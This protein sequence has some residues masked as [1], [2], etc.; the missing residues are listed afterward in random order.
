MLY[1]LHLI[2]ISENCY[3]SYFLGGGV[4]ITRKWNHGG[5]QSQLSQ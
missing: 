4:I 1:L 2:V 3:M 5:R